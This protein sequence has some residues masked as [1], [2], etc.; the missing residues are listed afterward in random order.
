MDFN[1]FV[2]AMAGWPMATV[3]LG[4][5]LAIAWIIVVVIKEL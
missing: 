2:D 4:L 5:T 1:K 3:M